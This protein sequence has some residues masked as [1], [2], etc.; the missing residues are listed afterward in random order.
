MLN[1]MKNKVISIVA[2][3]LPALPAAS[4]HHSS[5]HYPH[6]SNSHANRSLPEKFPYARPGKFL[7][8]F[9]QSSR[10]SRSTFLSGFLQLLT[11]DELKAS[12]DHNVRPILVPRDL[13]VMPWFTGYAECVNAGKSEWNEDNAGNYL[14][15]KSCTFVSF[16]LNRFL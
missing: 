16:F 10:S 13:N 2:P 15:I 12:A 8:F 3:D 9:P 5:H 11:Y 6:S 7:Q 4:G 1:R 14:I